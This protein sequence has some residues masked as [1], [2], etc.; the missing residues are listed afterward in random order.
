MG[1]GSWL[2][3]HQELQGSGVAMAWE[4]VWVQAVVQKLV[5]KPGDAQKKSFMAWQRS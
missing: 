1:R 3:L 2:Q 5:K 4:D